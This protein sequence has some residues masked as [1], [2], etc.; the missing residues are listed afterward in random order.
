[1]RVNLFSN[2]FQTFLVV[3]TG[4]EPVLGN[5]LQPA[6]TESNRFGCQESNLTFTFLSLKPLDSVYQLRHLTISYSDLFNRIPD[7]FYYSD[8]Y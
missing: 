3:R 8:K 4:L 5:L 6:H 1:M 2:F 7:P